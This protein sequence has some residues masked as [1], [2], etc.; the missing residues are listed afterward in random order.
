MKRTLDQL[1]AIQLEGQRVLVRVDF[2]TPLHDG[3]VTDDARIR[4]ALPTITHL[5]NHGARVVLLSHLDRPHGRP[6]PRYSLRPVQ[7]PAWARYRV[8]GTAG[9]VTLV[10]GPGRSRRSSIGFRKV[11]SVERRTA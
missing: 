2:N 7:L 8:R 3:V 6:D 1:D 10:A 4:A 5:R 9:G 11:R